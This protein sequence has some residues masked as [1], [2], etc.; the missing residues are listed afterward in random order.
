MEYRDRSTRLLKF[1]SSKRGD[2]DRIVAR[3]IG[4]A[5][6]ETCRDEFHFTRA[7]YF[8]IAIENFWNANHFT[9]AK[10][11]LWHLRHS[12]HQRKL[13]IIEERVLFRI[14]GE[15]SVRQCADQCRQ[16]FAFTKEIIC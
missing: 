7:K 6:I 13:W 8:A 12:E 4:L 3:L 16:F 11:A 5:G 14:D 10:R 2:R 9:K 1:F 15:N